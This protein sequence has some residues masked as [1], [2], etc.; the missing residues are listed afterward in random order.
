[1]SIFRGFNNEKIYVLIL[2]IF[3]MLTYWNYI[4]SFFCMRNCNK[5][6]NIIFIVLNIE[7]L[8]VLWCLLVTMRIDPGRSEM[9]WV[10]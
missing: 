1:M 9:F 6:S 10:R 5:N 7:T 3:F 8:L 4:L 2:I